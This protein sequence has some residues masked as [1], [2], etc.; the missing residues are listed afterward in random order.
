[1]KKSIENNIVYLT[2]EDKKFKTNR[3]SIRF[4]LPISKDTCADLV[5][6][7]DLMVMSSQKYNS[8]KLLNNH[9]S[10]LYDSKV[11]SSVFQRGKL[12]IFEIAFSYIS[13]DYLQTDIEREVISL[14]KEII[15][16]PNLE[17]DKYLEVTKNKRIL[18]IENVYDNKLQ[19]AFKQLK[20]MLDPSNQILVDVNSTIEEINAVNIETLKQTYLALIENSNITIVVNGREVSNT[21]NLL[22]Q[23]L[24]FEAK[25]N[26]YEIF[27]KFD[28]ND[29]KA[30]NCEHQDL[31][32]SKL[33]VGVKLDLDR[34]SFKTFQVFNAIYGGYPFSRLFSN[35]REKQSLAYSISSGYD[36]LL[37]LM[38]VYAGISN[39]EK[40]QTDEEVTE[41]VVNALRFELNSIVEGNVSD[42]E[43][44]QAKQMI[45]NSVKTSLD[46]Q[47]QVQD[48]Y[49]TASL[50]D[51]IFDL[52]EYIEDINAITKADVVGIA[53]KVSFDNIYLLR[54]EK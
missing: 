32:Q 33:M 47:S 46:T 11:A 40:S 30:F 24:L 36:S 22:K 44:E 10:K 31:M 26:D 43:L 27:H 52:E 1:M 25:I 34:D 23:E 41:K 50:H 53:K 14:A 28:I 15:F 13:K 2:N 35:I 18:E 17:N 37:N 51:K 8:I 39:G 6:L 49:Y 20:K 4:A 45:I 29:E 42:L 5:V 21:V 3:I 9:L 19:Y 7:N 38:Y 12:I 54:G 48:I 16:K